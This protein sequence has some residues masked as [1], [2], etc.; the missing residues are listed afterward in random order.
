MHY[1]N[2]E[3]GKTY[4][5]KIIIKQNKHQLSFFFFFFE[6]IKFVLFF[7]NLLEFMEC[8]RLW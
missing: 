5:I 3:I 7:S 8:G 2:S 6:S 1:E 4:I